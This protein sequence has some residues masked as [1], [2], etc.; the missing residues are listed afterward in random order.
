MTPS[1]HSLGGPPPG[2]RVDPAVLVSGLAAAAGAL[3]VLAYVVRAVALVAYPW[4][5]TPDEGLHLDYARRALEAPWTL[6]TRGA[7]VPFPAAYGPL[8]PFLTAPLVRLAEPL[9]AIRLLALGWTMAGAAAVGWLLQRRTGWAWAAAGVA[10]Y[11]SA[12]DMTFWNMLLRV[13]GLMITLWLWGAAVLLPGRLERG[14]DRLR[15]RRIATGSALLLASVLVKP[16]AVLYAA[17]LVLGWLLVDRRGAGWL[18]AT[19]TASGLGVLVLI[20]VATDGGF[21]WVNGLWLTH[22]RLPGQSLA[23]I[24]FF[25]LRAWPFLVLAAA[26]AVAA[27]LAGARPWREPGLLLLLG[28][29]TAVPL[30]GKHG[31]GWN[32]LLPFH[33]ALILASILWLE[34]AGQ[35]WRRTR[36]GRHIIRQG[37]PV[38]VAATALALAGTRAFPLPTGDDAATARAFYG[39]T[40]EVARRAG[41]PVLVARP[42]LVYF[43]LGQPVEIEGSSFAL[44]A[45]AGVPGTRGVL[46]RLRDREYTLVVETWSISNEPEFRAALETGYRYVGACVLGWYF[47]S[48]VPSHVLLRRDLTFDFISPA[49]GVRCT[50]AE[51]PPSS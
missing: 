41:G 19:L 47:G 24:G 22:P 27:T 15:P 14:A 29:L 32:Y 3:V 40:E 4:D 31:A 10:L 25:A 2:R 11:L 44:L 6:Y 23:L 37:P 46:D 38:L 17:P 36:P 21:L 39:Y 7:A 12:F 42:A 18:I 28:G 26:A 20:Q 9:A 43:L 35:S 34:Q 45:A 33:A 13:D 50:S 16:T 5:W 1:G 51:S 48:R 8:L 49:P 30:T